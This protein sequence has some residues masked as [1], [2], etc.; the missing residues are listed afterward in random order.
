MPR[1]TILNADEIN[2]FEKPPKFTSAQREKYFHLSDKLSA[3]KNKVTSDTS[4][5][6][7]V[8][9]WCIFC[10]ERTSILFLIRTV[11]LRLRE[12]E[13]CFIRTLNQR[14]HYC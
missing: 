7:I 14:A 9:Q 8:I 5:L 1:L 11:I 12:R 2:A 3:L 4:K 6:A 10:S 13:F